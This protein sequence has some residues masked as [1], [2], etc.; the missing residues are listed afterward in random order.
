[1]NK[2]SLQPEYKTEALVHPGPGG[3]HHLDKGKVGGKPE[4]PEC[5]KGSGPSVQPTPVVENVADNGDTTRRDG[6]CR[7]EEEEHRL[8]SV[9]RHLRLY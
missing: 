3:Q 6:H 9:Q 1:M 7:L 5:A 8:V 2:E 4:E